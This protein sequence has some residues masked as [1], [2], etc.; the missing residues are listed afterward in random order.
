M[1]ISSPPE[2]TWDATTT[3]IVF[4]A[5]ISEDLVI[6]GISREALRDN[7][8]GDELAPIGCIQEN[9]PTIETKIKALSS[10]GRHKT[11]DSYLHQKQ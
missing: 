3:C 5:T 1:L 8:N 10:K 9:R 2:E 4:P 7:F 11:N 6:C